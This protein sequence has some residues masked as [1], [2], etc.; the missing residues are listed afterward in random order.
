MLRDNVP[1]CD[2]G[3]GSANK[4][5]GD[6]VEK[7]LDVM[8]VVGPLHTGSQVHPVVLDE[9]ISQVLYA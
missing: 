8:E 5:P 2:F 1:F 4:A 3:L 6:S 7:L 9:K